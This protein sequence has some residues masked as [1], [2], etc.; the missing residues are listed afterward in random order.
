MALGMNVA[1]KTGIIFTICLVSSTWVTAHSNH[2]VLG[3]LFTAALS[4]NLQAI[5][6]KS[7]VRD[8]EPKRLDASILV[9]A[10]I[11]VFFLFN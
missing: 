11:I 9:S 10:Y 3:P 8:G 7:K 2:G 4:S 5:Q 1:I 6:C